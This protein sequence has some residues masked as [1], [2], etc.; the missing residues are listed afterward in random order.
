MLESLIQYGS[1]GLWL[2]T[3]LYEKYTFQKK[4]ETVVSNNTTA[5]I[6]VYECLKD[7]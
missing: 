1:I 5:L 4:M 3:M 6:K 7:K 2:V